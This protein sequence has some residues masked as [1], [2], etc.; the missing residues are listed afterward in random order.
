M[1]MIISMVI[2]F[3]ATVSLIV[4]AVMFRMVKG[5]NS[6]FANQIRPAQGD[7]NN[8]K[9]GQMKSP[10]SLPGHFC[11]GGMFWNDKTGM[12]EQQSAVSLDALAAVYLTR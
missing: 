10:E 2:A 7:L 1:S 4:L 11:S 6:A 12:H 5:Q 3:G 9:R 8:I